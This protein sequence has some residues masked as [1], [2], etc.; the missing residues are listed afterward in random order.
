MYLL[1]IQ[2]L[3]DKPKLNSEQNL[4]SEADTEDN[5]TQIP[6]SRIRAEPL[7]HLCKTLKALDH[8]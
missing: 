7:D 8:L 1:W 6:T 3:L 5:Q 2:T 4:A